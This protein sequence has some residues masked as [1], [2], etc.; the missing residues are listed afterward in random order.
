MQTQLLSIQTD[1]SSA[2][3]MPGLVVSY[4]TGLQC[5]CTLAMWPSG[6]RSLGFTSQALRLVG[7]CGLISTYSQTNISGRHRGPVY[8]LLNLW[9]ATETRFKAPRSLAEPGARLT[10]HHTT[11]IRQSYD[12]DRSYDKS[13]DWRDLQNIIWQSYDKILRSYQ[14]LSVHSNVCML[15]PRLIKS[16]VW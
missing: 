16:W 7:S 9:R 6:C 8:V 15:I 2:R 11:I 5:C 10:K 1:Q 12:D 14:I 4:A 3:I 13:Y